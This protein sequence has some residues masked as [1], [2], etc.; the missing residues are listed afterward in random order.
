VLGPGSAR[1][2]YHPEYRDGFSIPDFS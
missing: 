2:F 1:K